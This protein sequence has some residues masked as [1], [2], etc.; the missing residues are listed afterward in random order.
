MTHSVESSRSRIR[1]MQKGKINQSST[2]SL[3]LQT[4]SPRGKK[5]DEIVEVDQMQSSYQRDSMSFKS[6]RPNIYSEMG[7]RENHTH[8]DNTSEKS[9]FIIN[10]DQAIRSPAPLMNNNTVSE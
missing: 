8:D 10:I 9:K 6:V 4:T 5:G 3:H 7:G 1:R 2:N